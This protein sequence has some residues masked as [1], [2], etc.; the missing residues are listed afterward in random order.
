MKYNFL[1]ALFSCALL[2]ANACLVSKQRPCVFSSPDFNKSAIKNLTILPV[3]DLRTDQSVKGNFNKWA[4]KKAKFFLKRKKYAVQVD[5][6]TQKVSGLTREIVK[7]AYET[8]DYTEMINLLQP[9][10][11]EYVLLMTL[12]QW[13]SKF[14]FNCTSSAEMT[15]Y[16]FNTK[17]NKLIMKNKGSGDASVGPLICPVAIQTAIESAALEI[18]LCFPNK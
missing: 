17:T 11:A 15:G 4:Q 13:T 9:A 12:D 10:D 5:A 6:S 18:V 1:I 16:L 2:S 14:V 7:R 8:N 3:A